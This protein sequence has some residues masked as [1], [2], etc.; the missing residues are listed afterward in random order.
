MHCKLW[1]LE[2]Y[3][4]LIRSD[5]SNTGRLSGP[6]LRAP[7]A[8]SPDPESFQ[9][10]MRKAGGRPGTRNAARQAS[11]KAASSHPEVQLTNVRPSGDIPAFDDIEEEDDMSYNSEEAAG[12]LRGDTPDIPSAPT[13]TPSEQL[14]HD[15]QQRTGSAMSIDNPSRPPSRFR[16]GSAMDVDIPSRPSS[17]FRPGQQPQHGRTASVMSMASLD[18]ELQRI[19]PS[20]ARDMFPTTHSR[21]SPILGEPSP[22]SPRDSY[23]IG[24]TPPPPERFPRLPSSRTQQPRPPVQQSS[25]GSQM[26]APTTLGR[27]LRPPVGGHNAR[28]GGSSVRPSQRGGGMVAAGPSQRGESVGGNMLTTPGTSYEQA[29]VDR[30]GRREPNTGPHQLVNGEYWRRRDD[31]GV[32][33][34]VYQDGP[35]ERF[36]TLEPDGEVVWDGFVDR[37]QSPEFPTGNDYLRYRA[38]GRY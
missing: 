35:D 26:S 9:A 22:L 15:L 30:R 18:E 12:V 20:P 16:P 17:R 19:S 14:L 27:P 1:C 3:A 38:S 25:S 28:R 29:P 7:Q 33:Y 2:D 36:V 32:G 4:A 24:P 8:S 5:S 31:W 37:D 34:D 6:P 13:P 11:R 23:D 10:T 21:P